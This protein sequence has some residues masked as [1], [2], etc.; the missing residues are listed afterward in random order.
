LVEDTVQ[1]AK[2]A[3][4]KMQ[5]MMQQEDIQLGSQATELMTMLRGLPS[6]EEAAADSIR[7]VCAMAAARLDNLRRNMIASV[8]SRHQVRDVPL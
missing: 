7:H 5:E 6:R 8:K 1:D 2:R 3:I 4:S